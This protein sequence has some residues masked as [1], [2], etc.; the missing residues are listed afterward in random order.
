MILP[1]SGL[2]YLQSFVNYSGGEV[3]KETKIRKRKREDEDE[4]CVGANTVETTGS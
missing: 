1:S 2:E 3:L 4:D